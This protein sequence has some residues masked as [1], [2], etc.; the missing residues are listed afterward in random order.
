MTLG[1]WQPEVMRALRLEVFYDGLEGPSISTPIL[2]YFG[3]PH[4]R[5]AEYYSDLISVNEGRGL[6]SYIPLP[7]RH[8]LRAE[9][10]NE[11]SRHV[12]LFYQI[13]Y[14]L[15]ASISESTGYLHA[16]FRRDNP[17]TPGRDFVIAE[18]LKGPGRYLGCA[19]GIRVLDTSHWYGEGEVKIYRDGDRDYPTYCGTGLEDYVGSA[20][21][22]GRHYARYSGAPLNIPSTSDAS[23][24]TMPD[25]VSFYRWHLPD[26]IMFS[27]DLRVTIQQIA[28]C[29]FKQG[30]EADFEAYKKTHP[31]AAHGWLLEPTNGMIAMG[32]TERSDDYCATAFIYCR[33]PQIVAQYDSAEA[34]RDIALLPVESSI[35]PAMSDDEQDQL[36]IKLLGSWGE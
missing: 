4:G 3:L 24:I 16:V 20:Y 35:K 2:D 19:I 5:M 8:A 27:E 22:L 25:L 36:N 34:V 29:G 28:Y 10:S 12:T 26:P 6:N 21:G 13:D 14:T 9:L 32:L 23:R 11:S 33:N 15:A 1:R 7:F 18:G 30:Q 31:S 17:T